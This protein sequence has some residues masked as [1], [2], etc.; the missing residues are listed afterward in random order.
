MDAIGQSKTWR[1]RGKGTRSWKASGLGD[2]DDFL[3]AVG[4]G[5]R[6]AEAAGSSRAGW[7]RWVVGGLPSPAVADEQSGETNRQAARGARRVSSRST[8]S[9]SADTPARCGTSSR[10]RPEMRSFTLTAFS[11]RP[12]GV[13]CLLQQAR[14]LQYN[15]SILCNSFCLFLGTAELRRTM[16]SI[17]VLNRRYQSF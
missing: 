14:D 9:P 12:V 16:V 8:R 4:G 13:K 10:C 7:L 2:N 3:Q 5:M 11:T 6:Q 17:M 1:R 15:F